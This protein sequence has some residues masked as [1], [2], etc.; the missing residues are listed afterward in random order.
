MDLLTA[1]ILSRYDN[2]TQKELKSYIS[3]DFFEF[4][5]GSR[6]NKQ[7]L[8]DETQQVLGCHIYALG[9]W[10]FLCDD[11]KTHQNVVRHFMKPGGYTTIAS[12]HPQNLPILPVF[13]ENSTKFSIWT[14]RILLGVG[15]NNSFGGSHI[16]TI[17]S[18]NN[19][20]LLA[21]SYSSEI[22]ESSIDKKHLNEFVNAEEYKDPQVISV[23]ELLTFI[24]ENNYMCSQRELDSNGW[25]DAFG[26]S[27]SGNY[28]DMNRH[29]GV[30]HTIDD[31]VEKN[32][33]MGFLSLQ[34]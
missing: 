6:Q 7:V 25:I 8:Y 29:I 27:I 14:C 34:T 28:P 9:L 24:L 17:I 32:K 31:N 13:P 1:R 11:S 5:P 30:T 26:V 20:K 3:P 10:L 18:N 33:V 12:V 21:H 19:S 15:S 16:F 23:I 22:G 4:I 2:I